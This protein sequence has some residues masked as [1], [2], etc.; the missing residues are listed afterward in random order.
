MRKS[1]VLTATLALAGGLAAAG[2][3]ARDVYWSIGIQAPLH[4]GGTV[5]TVISNGPVYHSAPVYYPQPVYYDAVPVYYPQPVY[6]PAPVVYAPYPV[7][8]Q[9]RRVVY[10]PVWV[11]PGHAKRHWKHGDHRGRPVM[12][13]T[14]DR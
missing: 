6:R 13:T 5:G 9:P 10:A 4:Y 11:P 7:Y 2:A 3:Q 1:K 12:A 8:Y 14:Y